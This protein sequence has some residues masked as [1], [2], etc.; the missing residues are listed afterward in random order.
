MHA[1]RALTTIGFLALGLL[2]LGR[3]GRELNS[4]RA[5]DPA[6]E[7]FRAHV[8]KAIKENEIVL[9]PHKFDKG[10]CVPGGVV[11]DGET[12]PY[13]VV[14][15]TASLLEAKKMGLTPDQ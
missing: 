11:G 10:L 6:A 2:L 7:A 14:L 8:R 13:G 9:R 1:Q 15:E 5:A 4:A 12:S 3:S